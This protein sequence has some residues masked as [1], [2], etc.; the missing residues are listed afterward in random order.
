[1]QKR[2]KS[3]ILILCLMMLCACQNSP[4]EPEKVEEVQSDYEVE[5]EHREGFVGEE[6]YEQSFAR[7]QINSNIFV[8]L[9]GYA[10]DDRKYAYFAGNDLSE[11]FYVFETATNERVYTG[12]LKKMTNRKHEGK[13]I[14]KG[15]F[16][17][18]TEPGVY[19]IQTAV[20]GQSYTFRIDESRYES[21]Y[22]ELKEEF[23]ALS[24]EEYYGKPKE[25]E[26]RIQIYY[27]FQKLATAYQFFPEAF[28]ED[29]EKKLEEHAQWLVTMRE[30]LLSE[31]DAEQKENQ[32]RPNYAQPQEEEKEIVSED[33]IFA[34]SMAAGYTVLQPYNA[35]LAGKCLSQAQKAYQNCAHYKVTGDVQYMAAASLFR[36]VGNY[37]YHA[38]IKDKYAQQEP[39]YE[40]L[41]DEKNLLCD[42]ILWGNLFY[43]T[44]V[45]G[46]DMAICD[47][48]MAGLMD[49]CAGYM[50]K[51]PTRAFGLIHG[52]EESLECA[53]WLTVADYIIVSLEYRNVCKE[54]IHPLL[55]R[56]D[57]M[58]LSHGQKSTLIM[59]LVN[60]AESEEKE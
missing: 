53:V 6:A 38:I 21:Q 45:K 59:I 28:G 43:M 22:G 26:E 5:M 31:R 44:A 23:L 37:T 12:T 2:K 39:E 18:V 50:D 29:F 55:Y 49:L 20:I 15:D 16:S 8:D 13:Q 46:A 3:V 41:R 60:L 58:D 56:M 4:K 27:S 57:E 7:P 51:A 33:Y 30:E 32:W 17:A 11:S 48:Q 24:P 42:E 10:P 1:M 19:Y 35:P 36:A 25:R 34:S 52:K 40:K 47:K 14:Y 54:Q 9:M